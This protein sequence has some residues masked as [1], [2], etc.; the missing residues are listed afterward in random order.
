MTLLTPLLTVGI[1]ILVG[2]LVIAVM[3]AI[4]SINEI[5]VR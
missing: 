2:S 4:L 5:A 1:A 3:N